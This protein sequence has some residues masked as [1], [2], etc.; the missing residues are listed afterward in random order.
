MKDGM[1]ALIN[2]ISFK[3]ATHPFLHSGSGLDDINGVFDDVQT[4]EP[5]TSSME[6][7]IMV[8]FTTYFS[9]SWI[10]HFFTFNLKGFARHIQKCYGWGVRGVYNWQKFG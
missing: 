4:Y 2:S 7:E 6:V 5:T 1:N 8:A 10:L 3:S 9:F